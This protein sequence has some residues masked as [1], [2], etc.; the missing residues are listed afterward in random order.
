MNGV[1]SFLLLLVVV[2]GLGGY[3]YYDSKHEPGDEKKQEK[4]FAGVQSDKIERV[5]VKSASGDQTTVEKQGNG[6]AG[7]AAGAPCR[8]TKRRSPASPRTWPRSRSSASSTIRRPTSSSTASTRRASRSL[9]SSPA[10]IRSCCIGQKTPTGTD[11]YAKVPDKP[12]VF[13]VASF[14]ESTFN[15]SSFDLRDKTILKIDRDKVDR[16]EIETPDHT[17][18][19]AKQGADW[20]MSVA[21]RRAR[22][23]RRGGR[24]H[25]PAQH[26]RR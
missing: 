10:R 26:R 15:K 23:L 17:V 3:L 22:G 25:R 24:D 5:T 4:V 13:L 12:R 18:K 2:A 19:V 16:I 21:G 7:H 8:P 1:R 20:R 9:S 6:L 11:V 14:L